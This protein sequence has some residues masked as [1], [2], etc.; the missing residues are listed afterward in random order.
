MFPETALRDLQCPG[1][2]WTHASLRAS[3]GTGCEKE[4]KGGLGKIG[5]RSCPRVCWDP[6][7]LVSMVSCSHWQ[8]TMSPEG[9]Q[10][11]D[12]LKAQQRVSWG[13]QSGHQTAWSLERL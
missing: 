8:K 7:E 11:E 9:Q 10:R 2:G 4:G 6:M 5:L 3:A 1:E 13:P 12:G